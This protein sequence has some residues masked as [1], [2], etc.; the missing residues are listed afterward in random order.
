MTEKRLKLYFLSTPEKTGYFPNRVFDVP[1]EMGQKFIKEGHCQDLEYT[2]DIDLSHP[3]PADQYKNINKAYLE[4]RSQINSLR[5]EYDRLK[6]LAGRLRTR[7]ESNGKSTTKHFSLISELKQYE[8]KMAE[9][10]PEILDKSDKAFQA[11]IA[12]LEAKKLVISNEIEPLN[13]AVSDLYKKFKEADR[14]NEKVRVMFDEI[15][16]NLGE[17]NRHVPSLPYIAPGSAGNMS[18]LYKA[19]KEYNECIQ[20]L[21]KQYIQSTNNK[22]NTLLLGLL[23]EEIREKMEQAR[24]ENAEQ[25]T[26]AAKMKKVLSEIIK[27][28]R[29]QKKRKEEFWKKAMK[30]EV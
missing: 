25:N 12:R 26:T 5:T 2:P 16:E 21:K 27:K 4:L 11:N 7:I 1:I 13:K 30:G 19:P 28:D 10:E 24:L 29:A 20:N 9:I 17:K 15:R 22:I 23:N 3:N 18:H 8:A 6:H 14:L